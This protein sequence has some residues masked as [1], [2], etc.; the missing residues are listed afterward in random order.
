MEKLTDKNF[1]R[2]L[3]ACAI[4]RN[5]TDMDD[6]EGVD[7]MGCLWLKTYTSCMK[8]L[9]TPGAYLRIRPVLDVNRITGINGGVY[10]LAVRRPS[11]H[12]ETCIGYVRANHDSDIL[13]MRTIYPFVCEN[14]FNK[15]DVVEAY[16]VLYVMTPLPVA[17]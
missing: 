13:T 14:D 17:L 7:Q 1:K 2:D 4:T 12:I 11:G 8:P 15:S 16:A 10:V 3:P 9:I 5:K 6:M